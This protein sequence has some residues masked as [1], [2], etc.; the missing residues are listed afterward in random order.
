MTLAKEETKKK[1][2]KPYL[3]LIVIGIAF[4]TFF[5]F[6]TIQISNTGFIH[7]DYEETIFKFNL[8]MLCFMI[9]MWDCKVPNWMR[10]KIQ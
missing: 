3:N 10:G 8:L 2:I 4:Y 9:I 6:N 1:K 5:T 7:L